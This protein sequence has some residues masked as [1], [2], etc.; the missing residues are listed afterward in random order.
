MHALAAFAETLP[1]RFD[2]QLDLVY[3]ATL[4]TADVDAFLQR[5]NADAHAAIRARFAG[6]RDAG[7]W[8]PQRNDIAA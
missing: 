3:A 8:H 7:L 4:G 6:L 2:R 5:E 1:D